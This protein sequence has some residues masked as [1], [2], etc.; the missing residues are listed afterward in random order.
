MVKLQDAQPKVSVAILTWNRREHVLRAIES[1]LRQPY[2]PLEVVVVD[3]ASNDGTA[4]VIEE[5]YPKVRLIR[6]HRNLG[7][8]EGRNIAMANCNGEILF[9][10]D[11]DAWVDD[12]TIAKCVERFVN[13]PDVGIIAC[14]V[15]PPGTSAQGEQE[16][17]YTNRFSG[18]AC[19]IRREVLEIVGYYPSDFHRQGEESDLALR[20]LEA[21]YKILYVPSATV[22]HVSTGPSKR[23]LIYLSCR[24]DLYTVVRRYPGLFVPVGFIWKVVVWNWAGLK[25]FALHYSLLACAVAVFRIPW[26]VSS[27]KPVSFATIRL[28]LRLRGLQSN[29][30]PLCPETES[31]L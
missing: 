28:W 30:S 21:G 26:L 9:C 14:R 2:R 27:R 24:N 6:L 29:C 11:D 17:V 15:L 19:A 13:Y 20:V 22:F 16:D 5:L 3:S 25:T 23:S 4:K 18:G 31:K 7:C 12:D 8:P 1:V 10:L